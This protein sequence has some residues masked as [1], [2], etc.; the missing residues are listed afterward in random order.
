MERKNEYRQTV[1]KTGASI[2]ANATIV[3]GVTLGKFCFVGAGSVVTKDVPD[4]ALVY[5][6]PAHI[7]G[8]VCRCGEKLNE[9]LFCRTCSIGYSSDGKGLRAL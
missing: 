6:S 2:G 4:H 9:K 7:H 5:G 8:W 3:C 1:V